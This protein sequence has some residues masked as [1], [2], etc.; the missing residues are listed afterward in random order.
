MLSP[1]LRT[2][3]RTA[4]PGTL[5][6]NLALI[7][8][9]ALTLAL[10]A[11]SSPQD[12][13]QTAVREQPVQTFSVAER[14]AAQALSIG[15]RG[16][17][18]EAA[19]PYEQALACSHA[20]EFITERFGE[21]GALTD[22]QVQA[23]EQVKAVYDRRARTLGNQAGRSAEEIRADLRDAAEESPEPREQALQAMGCLQQLDQPG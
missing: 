4:L 2:T 19:G 21:S 1:A 5:A 13:G 20:I 15:N 18:P 7:L 12:D 16:T 9:L 11:C 22:Q 8:A 6:A 23:V 14:A 17:V 10:A 3:L